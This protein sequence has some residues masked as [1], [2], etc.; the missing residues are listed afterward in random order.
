VKRML[1][2]RDQLRLGWSIIR[3]L[4]WPRDEPIWMNVTV[5]IV[6]TAAI[7]GFHNGMTWAF[8]YAVIITFACIIVDRRG[9]KDRS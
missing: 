9:G 1:P 3:W 8:A 2:V 4:Y 7:I 6:S 5:L